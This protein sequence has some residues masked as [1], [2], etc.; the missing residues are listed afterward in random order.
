MI[1]QGDYRREISPGR[2]ALYDVIKLALGVVL[3][4]IF[5]AVLYQVLEVLS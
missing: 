4:G 2:R 5:A 3:I 1:G